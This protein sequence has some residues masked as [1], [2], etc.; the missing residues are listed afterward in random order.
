[1]NELTKPQMCVRLSSGAEIWIDKEK[2]DTLRNFLQDTKSGFV[3]IG[4]ETVSVRDISGIFTPEAVEK[5]RNIWRG[6]WECSHGMWHD[7]FEKC[8]CWRT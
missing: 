6:L 8:E 2:V 1:M 4:E 7:R 5:Y 3:Q